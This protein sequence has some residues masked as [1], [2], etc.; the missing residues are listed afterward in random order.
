MLGYFIWNSGGLMYFWVHLKTYWQY[1]VFENISK[2][3]SDYKRQMKCFS[4][5]CT[6]WQFINLIKWWQSKDIFV[7]PMKWRH[8]DTN[9]NPKIFWLY[10]SIWWSEYVRRK[11]TKNANEVHTEKAVLHW[12]QRPNKKLESNPEPSNWQLG[13]L[14]LS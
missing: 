8:K 13:A 1:K 12:S 14:P 9:I 10:S 7:N 6:T 5:L 4:Y 11:L 3:W 2:I